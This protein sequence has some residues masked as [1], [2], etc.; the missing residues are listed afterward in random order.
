MRDSVGLEHD[1]DG[2]YQMAV[3]AGLEPERRGQALIQWASTLRNLGRPERAIELLAQVDDPSMGDAPRA[4]LALS[5]SDAGR[6]REALRVALEALAPH[7]PR[8]QRAVNAYAR[9]L[10]EPDE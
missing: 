5:L 8:Y 1:A 3:Q 4:F 7:L 6:D 2:Y 10:T 9:L